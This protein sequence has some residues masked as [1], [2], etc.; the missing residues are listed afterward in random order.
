MARDRLRMI[1]V[2]IVQ[3]DD[4]AGGV[5]ANIDRGLARLEWDL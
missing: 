1:Q 4:A 2:R 5:T 3:L